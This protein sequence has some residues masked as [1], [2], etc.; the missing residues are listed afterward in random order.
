MESIPSQCD[1]FSPSWHHSNK[2][3]GSDRGE[4]GALSCL[5]YKFLGKDFFSAAPS[6]GSPD[7]REKKS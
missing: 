4:F 6:L 3:L 7:N 2:L 1:F 5:H